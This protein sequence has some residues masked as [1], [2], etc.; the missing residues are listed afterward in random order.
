MS[1]AASS[2]T[3]AAVPNP[4]SLS[5]DVVLTASVTPAAATGTVTFL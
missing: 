3:L 2:L 4:V 5:T 1:V